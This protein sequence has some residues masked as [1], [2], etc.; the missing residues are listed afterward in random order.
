[1]SNKIPEL[2]KKIGA[3]LDKVSN[4]YPVDSSTLR[5]AMQDVLKIIEEAER[6]AR[7]DEIHLM[8]G[9]GLIDGHYMDDR[10]ATLKQGDSK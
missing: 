3:I 6:A 1:M 2:H 10:L 8:R 9:K 7:I 4:E 5:W